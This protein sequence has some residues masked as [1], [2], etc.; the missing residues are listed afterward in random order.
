MAN[1]NGVNGGR[2]NPGRCWFIAFACAFRWLCLVF[3]RSYDIVSC[4]CDNM[5]WKQRCNHTKSQRN[6]ARRTYRIGEQRLKWTRKK[7][8]KQL[9]IVYHGVH[10]CRVS[11]LFV[12]VKREQHEHTSLF[13]PQIEREKKKTIFVSR[14]AKLIN[15]SFVHVVVD[16]LAFFRRRQLCLF[17]C[18]YYYCCC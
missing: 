5:K 14:I 9:T 3:L 11:C 7:A 2:Q 12:C 17:A 16:V 15:L 8:A 18:Y 10:P 6:I 1:G 13:R 4:R